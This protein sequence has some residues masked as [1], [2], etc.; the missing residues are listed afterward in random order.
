MRYLDTFSVTQ[1]IARLIFR[2]LYTNKRYRLLYTIKRSPDIVDLSVVRIASKAFYRSGVIQL[3]DR[4]KIIKVLDPKRTISA[5]Y[6][7]ELPVRTIFNTI[8]GDAR[9]FI[10][11][12]KGILLKDVSIVIYT[13]DITPYIIPGDSLYIRSTTAKYLKALTYSLISTNQ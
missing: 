7:K 10:V 9:F 5:T 6:N 11:T 8:D 1:S 3:I 12:L 2:F 13:K 4:S